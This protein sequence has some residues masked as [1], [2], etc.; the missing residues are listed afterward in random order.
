MA[1]YAIG[2]VQGCYSA[3]MRLLDV[4]NYNPKRDRLWFAGDLVNRGPE[5]L[6]VLRFVKDQGEAA[7]SVLGNHDIH[8]LAVA[9]GNVKHLRKQ[10]TLD[11]IL[12]A[13]DRDE[14]IDWLRHRPFLHHDKSLGYSMVHAGLPPQWSLK[15]AKRC[16]RELE[17]QLQGEHYQYFIE[18]MF[19][20]Q[21]E[22]WDK[23]AEDWL[24]WR[25][26]LAC[27]TRL[28]YCSKQGHLLM[29]NKQHP[30]TLTPED[31]C[32]P[33][34]ICPKRKSKGK[35]IIFGHWSTLGLHQQ[36]KTWGLDSGCLWGGQLTAF[37][38]ETKKITQV[39]CQVA[40]DPMAF[41]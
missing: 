39:D 21:L 10:D 20:E 37:C 23:N 12:A 36:K 19:G 30:S 13:P 8:L 18:H 24:R 28:R 27:F 22:T 7:I 26:S 1:T 41:V 33:W 32:Y 5:S 9:Y 34:F 2:D 11:G 16:A 38:L 14:L 40:Q 35:R 29:K 31:N 15:T 17:A 3:L 25:F 4:L 6:A